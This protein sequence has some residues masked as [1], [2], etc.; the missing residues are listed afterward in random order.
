MTVGAGGT[1]RATGDLGDGADVLDVA[2]TLDTAAAPSRS[3]PAT[4]TSSCTTARVTGTVDGGA[5]LDT[6]T[7]N[8]NTSADLGA[9]VNFEGVTKTGTGV[10]NITGPGATD[11][12]AV[13]VLGGTL[14]VAA[15]ASVVA[16]VGTSL[17]TLVAGGATLN[18][19]GAYGCGDGND[20]MTVSG[21]VTGSGTIDLCGG[22]DTLT[23]GDGAVLNNTISG[24]T[25]GSGD[26]VVLDNAGALSFD[27]SRT[28]DFELLVKNNTGEATLTGTQSYVGGTTLNDGILERRRH[29]RHT[30]GSDGRRH[31]AERRRH[32][33]GGGRDADRDHRQRRHQYSECG[34]RRHAARDRRSGRRC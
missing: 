30:D 28:I 31:G 10:L 6:R 11:L 4:T 3:A 9:L 2:G 24:G 18:V 19:Q 21:A 34:R 23:L 27:A 25:H 29:A 5:G 8:I 26:T 32:V 16:S 22:E 13:D 17:N 7:Y 20:A 12:Q 33:A 1:L 15:G 14:E